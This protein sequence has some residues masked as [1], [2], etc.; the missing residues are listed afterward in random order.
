[1]YIVVINPTA[2]PWQVLDVTFDSC[3]PSPVT[4]SAINIMDP[5]RILETCPNVTIVHSVTGANGTAKPIRI[6]E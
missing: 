5:V 6:D 1:M 2:I 3:P 4:Y